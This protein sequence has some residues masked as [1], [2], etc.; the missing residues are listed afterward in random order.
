MTDSGHRNQIL[1]LILPEVRS[2]L[3]CVQRRRQAQEMAVLGTFE[4]AVKVAL[5][6]GRLK[7]F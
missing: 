3:T 2:K 7:Y 1:R 5:K 4:S 6:I